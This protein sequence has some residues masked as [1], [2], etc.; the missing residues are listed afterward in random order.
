[1]IIYIQI[2]YGTFIES[3]FVNNPSDWADSLHLYRRLFLYSA[4]VI[5]VNESSLFL[6]LNEDKIDA[7]VF[8][9][10]AIESF[11]V[12]SSWKIGIYFS[13]KTT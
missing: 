11:V 9:I 6:F 10:N 3:N 4:T 7:K 12:I 8:V 2:D 1:M 13:V 5:T